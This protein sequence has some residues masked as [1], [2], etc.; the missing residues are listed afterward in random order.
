MVYKRPSRAGQ[1]GVSGERKQG[2]SAYAM[3]SK[4]LAQT[5]KENTALKKANADHQK[6]EQAME[7][8]MNRQLAINKDN[9]RFQAEHTIK[10]EWVSDT[11]IHM[12]AKWDAKFGDD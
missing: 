1:E 8:R 12:Q 4:L 3:Q 2:V 9:E 11:L 7:K 5:I 10:M 6:R